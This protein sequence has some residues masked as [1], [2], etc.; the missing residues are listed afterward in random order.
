MSTKTIWNL[1]SDQLDNSPI[2]RGIIIPM[3]Q[4]DYAQGRNNTKAEEIRKVF[5][6]DLF[7]R[8]IAVRDEN[9]PP[10]ELDFIYGY[11][12][13][14]AFVPLDGQQ[15]L[16]T[17]Y[18]LHWYLAYNQ[19]LLNKY[20]NP[21]SKFSYE[22][23]KSSTDFFKKINTGLNDEDYKD[24]F[25]NKASFK[26]VIS[27]KNWYFIDWKYDLTVQSAITMLDEIHNTYTLEKYEINFE[28]LIHQES[29]SI[30]FNFLDIK[31]YGLSDDLYI[32]MNA[33]GK[34]L[35]NFENLK[36]ELNKYIRKSDFNDSHNYKI[37]HSE[38][39]KPV[40]VETYFATKIDTSWT[41]YFWNLR[42]T[43]TS[44]FDDK[45][46]NLLAFIS[47]NELTRI[48]EVEADYCLNVFK[49]QSELT[50]YRFKTLTLLNEK[51]IITFIEVL[52]LLISSNEIIK[53]YL[54]VDNEFIGKKNIISTTFNSSTIGDPLYE[55]RLMFYAITKFLIANKKNI[56]SSELL[57]WD[58]LIRNL[59]KNDNYNKIKDLQR[60]IAFVDEL[61]ANYSGDIYNTF[62]S[63]TKNGFDAQQVKEEKLKIHLIIKSQR[64]KDF[65][66]EVEAHPYLNGQIIFSLSF[67]GIYDLYL[68]NKL[69]WTDQEDF[70]LFNKAKEYFEKFKN[71]FDQSGLREF[72][73]EIF[74][75][76]LL[77]KGDYL[78]YS[79]NWSFLINR[80]RDISWKR[81]LKESGN[82]INQTY[83]P[84]VGYLK[85]L[86]DEVKVN[87][88]NKSLSQI[89]KNHT[90]DDWRK[91]FI[92]TP[93]LLKRS[94]G[95]YIK[96][97]DENQIYIL[98]KSKYNKYKDPHVQS[99]LLK[100]ALE[101]N[102][103]SDV[104]IKLEFIESLNQ[105]GISQVRRRKPKIV[106]NHDGAN[107]YL[108]RQ[109]GK[110]DKVFETQSD[111]LEYI[112]NRFS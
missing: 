54:T 62:L 11:I 85:K 111:T 79:T 92:E 81:L 18:L 55:V 71:F 47:I 1:L 86:F 108:I 99:I 64:W 27:N 88:V 3:I 97:F 8:I 19:K 100:D 80:H 89:I 40:N 60:N 13:S 105:Y 96:F 24:I 58:R 25:I 65:I 29:P 66:T 57:K 26:T 110:E 10:L 59:S 52:D 77:T 38:G 51:T 4:R 7:E 95:K 42:N 15:R 31:N 50:F 23:R 30:V 43:E 98:R 78:L 82:R 37:E 102:G 48:N 2:P 75:R 45:L 9:A 22:T 83:I 109:K 17:L 16:S 104:D 33:R 72:D 41:D 107:K 76:A 36:A 74:R 101:K 84:R 34:P 68:E 73:D 20:K 35:T 32:K 63:I 93:S 5:L 103:F 12:K 69:N 6:S 44:E 46:L 39:T 112:K 21:F 90:C 91:D 70:I 61:I 67:A 49:V 56:T 87:E 106:Y 53:K 94:N 28:T 14:K